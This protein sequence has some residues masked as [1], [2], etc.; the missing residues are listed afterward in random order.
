M[1]FQGITPMFDACD[2]ACECGCFVDEYR[3]EI[4]HGFH[5]SRCEKSY[6]HKE[7]HYWGRGAHKKY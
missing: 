7:P 4:E 5:V 2:Y 6:T 3:V 1:V